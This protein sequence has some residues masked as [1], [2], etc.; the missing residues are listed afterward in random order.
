MEDGTLDEMEEDAREK[1]KTRKRKRRVDDD[2]DMDAPSTSRG[3][4]V[5]HDTVSTADKVSHAL[6]SNQCAGLL[7][8]NKFYCLFC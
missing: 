1:K 8:G 5:S 4:K 2:Y 7:C 3:D 6:V